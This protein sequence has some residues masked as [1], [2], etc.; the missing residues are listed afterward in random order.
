MET[1]CRLSGIF[2]QTIL[3]LV[4]GFALSAGRAEQ[5]L[6]GFH[7]IDVGQ[8]A[9][10]LIETRCGIVLID[11]GAQDEEHADKL[12]AYLDKVFERRTDLDKTIALLGITH[13]HVDHNFALPKVVDSFTVKRYIDT[14][15]VSGSGRTQAQWIRNQ[16]QAGKPIELRELKNA[17]V[18]AVPGRKGL[19]NDFIDPLSCPDCDPLIRVLSGSRATGELSATALGTENNHSIVWRIDFGEIALLITGDL[20]T[21]GIRKL[22]QDYAGTNTLDVD[23]YEVGHH[24]SEN[25]T[26]QALLDAMTPTRAI[27][28]VGKWDF[29]RVNPVDQYNTYAYGHPRQTLVQLLEGGI[30]KSRQP[31]TI[32][33]A[34]GQRNFTTYI[35]REAV[36]GTGFDGNIIMSGGLDGTLRT[37]TNQ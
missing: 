22:I 17:D 18:L 28:G 23:L 8:G 21:S 19:T 11:A 12:V 33:A 31:K 7:F 37:R 16:I 15:R 6:I 24:G 35:V 10:T 27:M 5:P 32:K 26:T 29:G 34:L 14:G 30:S 13:T 4:S 20:E 1:H 3:A 25:G 2:I 9:A 36:Y